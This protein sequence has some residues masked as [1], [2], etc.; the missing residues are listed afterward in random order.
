MPV[1][2]HL[3][4]IVINKSVISSKYKGG[5]PEFRKSYLWDEDSYN[6][7]DDELFALASMNS[8]EHEIEQLRTKGLDYDATLQRSDDFTILSRYE[9]VLWEVAWL[10]HNS[11]FAWHKNT[12]DQFIKRAVKIENMPMAEIGDLM[13]IGQNPFRTIRSW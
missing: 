3:S 7:E 1:F 8:D 5:I 11:T 6:Q 4:I 12:D 9:G 10:E 2:I 13:D